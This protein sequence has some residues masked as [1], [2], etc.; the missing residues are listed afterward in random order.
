MIFY[1]DLRELE[2]NEKFPESELVI[3]YTLDSR[4]GALCFEVNGPTHYIYDEKGVPKLD[5]INLLK[6]GFLEQFGF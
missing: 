1:D 6:K 4:K 2:N 3:P 5:G